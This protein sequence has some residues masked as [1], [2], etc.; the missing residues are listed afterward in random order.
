LL[1]DPTVLWPTQIRKDLQT[2]ATGNNESASWYS[3]IAEAET[4]ND[5]YR[6][7]SGGKVAKAASAIRLNASAPTPLPLAASRPGSLGREARQVRPARPQLS[8]GAMVPVTGAA[9]KC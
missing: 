4:W 6:S 7:P 8:Y 5:V 1:T 3:S 2:V 9:P